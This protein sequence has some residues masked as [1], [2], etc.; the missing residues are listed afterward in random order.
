MQKV[1]EISVDN[2]RMMPIGYTIQCKLPDYKA[3]CTARSLI[4]QM[5]RELQC[6]FKTQECPKGSFILLVT[7]FNLNP[8]KN[9]NPN[10]NL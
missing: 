9:G 5:K 1:K 7:K 10:Q 3:L 6:E 8:T 2:L 4:S